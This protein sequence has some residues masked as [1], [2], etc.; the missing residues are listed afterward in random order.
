VLSWLFF[1]GSVSDDELETLI[2][3]VASSVR[4]GQPAA[5]SSHAPRWSGENTSLTRR[6]LAAL[7]TCSRG[8]RTALPPGYIWGSAS[9]VGSSTC[10]CGRRSELLPVYIWGSAS[11]VRSSPSPAPRFSGLLLPPLLLLLLFEPFRRSE[12]CWGEMLKASPGRGPICWSDPLE[13][14]C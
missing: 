2:A 11:L 1:L 12:L 4:L 7:S 6:R 10:S 3:G 13:G 9:P 14:R 8:R 5:T